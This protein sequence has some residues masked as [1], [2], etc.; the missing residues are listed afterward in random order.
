MHEDT[1]QLSVVDER[2]RNRCG[3]MPPPDCHQRH[4][5]VYRKRSSQTDS[6]DGL[7]RAGTIPHSDG[8]RQALALLRHWSA[9]IRIHVAGGEVLSTSPRRFARQSCAVAVT[10]VV[11]VLYVGLTYWN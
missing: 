3:T 1:V 11:S 6:G 5:A 7:R 8:Q 10:L 2:R 4:P 9:F